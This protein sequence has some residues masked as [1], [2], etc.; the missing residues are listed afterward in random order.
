M[1][2]FQFVVEQCVRQQS[3]LVMYYM[4]IEMRNKIVS[5]EFVKG[6]NMVLSETFK[7][8]MVR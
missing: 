1:A 3:D 2:E 7:W 6:I 5:E 4:E 8:Y